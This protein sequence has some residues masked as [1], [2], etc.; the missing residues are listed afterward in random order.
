MK[1][2][3][4]LLFTLLAALASCSDGIEDVAPAIT[5]YTGLALAVPQV[6]VSSASKTMNAT[7]D[8]CKAQD[9][10]LFCFPQ[11]NE[12]GEEK[13]EKLT[14]ELT[15]LTAQKDL[16][17]DACL[18][19]IVLQPGTYHV[20]VVANMENNSIW[21]DDNGTQKLFKDLTEEQLQA[22]TEDQLKALTLSYDATTL[23]T[24]GN[25][26]M[27]Y[28]SDKDV[29]VYDG[30]ATEVAANLTFTCAKVVVNIIFD[31]ANTSEAPKAAKVFNGIN[32]LLTPVEAVK[33]NNLTSST[34]LFTAPATSGDGA[35][36]GVALPAGKFYDNYTYNEAYKN[37]T[38]KDVVTPSGAA[39]TKPTNARPWLYR[40]TYYLP[41][42][43][44]TDVNKATALP[45][46]GKIIGGKE[47]TNTYNNISGKNLSTESTENNTNYFKLERGHYYEIVSFVNGLGQYDL[48]TTV[49]VKDWETVNISADF[50]HTTL[51][52]EK[53]AASIGSLTK[54]S[55]EYTTNAI[56]G[57]T[58]GCV[59]QVDSKD[60]VSIT[61][62][63]DGKKLIFSIN[64]A[65]SMET[66]K[67]KGAT[68]GTA[69]VWI[70]AGN[71]KKYINVSYNVTPFLIVTP[72]KEVIYWTKEGKGDP[73]L[74]KT[75][76][77]KTNLGGI[78]F[79]EGDFTASSFKENTGGSHTFGQSTIT[80]ECS[81]NQVA[82][83]TIT[84]TADTDPVT[85]T[86][87]TFTVYPYPYK[88]NDDYKKLAK[89]V[90]VT[91]KPIAGDYRIYMRAINDLQLMKSDNG[92]ERVYSLGYL[93]ESWWRNENNTPG[94]NNNGNWLDGWT[95]QSSNPANYEEQK[96][97]NWSD[98]ANAGNHYAYIYTQIGETETA[99]E[100][101]KIPAWLFTATWPG[102]EMT[103]DAN[104]PGW[105]YIN[106]RKE[107]E[108]TGHIANSTGTKI[109][110]PGE[111]LIIF[112][113][114]SNTTK[115][116]TLHRF[117]HHLDPGIPLF[118]FEDHE[119]WYLYDPL[120][121]PYYRVF[122]D[123]PKVEDITYVIYTKV[124]VTGW[125]HIYGVAT[126]V[127]SN[128]LTDPNMQSFSIYSN[129]TNSTIQSNGWYKMTLKFKC[130]Q[131]YYDKAIRLK[132][133]GITNEPVLFG[134]ASWPP[135]G[136]TITGYYDGSSWNE[137]AP[138]GAAA[139]R[140]R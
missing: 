41:E 135:D 67:A 79:K 55:V 126:N 20:Y 91:V 33:G 3:R 10:Y 46:T 124:P 38:N 23:P 107:K 113:D 73:T 71:I 98:N 42:R 68:T 24:A 43:S 93:G 89:E 28:A 29:V 51:W 60:V 59:T 101:D 133:S 83:G 72:V 65:I 84:V 61:E 102:D 8:E 18:Y 106:E 22:L 114:R 74:V 128:T 21:M 86:E 136:K 137:G 44:V 88:D 63:K 78:K 138:K 1:P 92:G 96:T 54:D 53:T 132:L 17:G 76:T 140:R 80:V 112:N 125:Y 118:N 75:L 130:A 19:N 66:F 34:N 9:L 103:A 4:F 5:S 15:G 108:S 109:I 116:Y 36:S 117:T 13:G 110:K 37:E 120:C 70:Q 131:G 139:K 111:T 11:K 82:E 69:K 12:K 85:T 30:K 95:Y 26:P 58:Y 90:L 77:F 64:P 62:S 121:D 47:Y 115:G 49:N 40:A 2:F 48:P 6:T 134:G 97:I 7:E 81:H 57:I 94:L 52:V 25:I 127:T 27:V 122:D 39:V 56:K 14:K 119:G 129:S 105:Y 87:H 32:W 100:K 123:K 16:N 45:V 31:P 50:L 104:N 99:S 35:L